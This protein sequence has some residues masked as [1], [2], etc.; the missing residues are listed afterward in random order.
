MSTKIKL[1]KKE[2]QQLSKIKKKF[3]SELI[4]DRAHAV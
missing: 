3:K 4:R 2:K 1:I